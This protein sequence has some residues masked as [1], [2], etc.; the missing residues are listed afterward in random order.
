MHTVTQPS[1]R[2]S[3][4]SLYPRRRLL[5][6]NMSAAWIMPAILPS[7][8][9]VTASR[10]NFLHVDV[11]RSD[12]IPDRMAILPLLNRAIQ[13]KFLAISPWE[14]FSR[15]ARACNC[16]IFQGNFRKRKTQTTGKGQSAAR[17]GKREAGA[18]AAGLGAHSLFSRLMPRTWCD[19]YQTTNGTSAEMVSLRWNGK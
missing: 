19:V 13:V 18:P 16:L 10:S 11:V 4:T 8:S 7:F 17:A 14:I 5:L 1:P 3:L 12:W 15:A 9:L 6:R 2:R